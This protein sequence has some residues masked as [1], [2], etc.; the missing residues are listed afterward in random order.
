MAE[1]RDATFDEYGP[2]VES[3]TASSPERID[4]APVQQVGDYV[5]EAK[6]GEGGFG[7]VYRAVHRVIGKRVAIKV[8]SPKY[9]TDP[10]VLSRFISE[11]RAVN[12]I[13]HHHIVDIFS[14]GELPDGRRY[15]VM[16]YLEGQTLEA[17]LV[18][19]G[20]LPLSEVLA[21]LEP[22]ARALDAAHQAGIA[23]RDLK[24]A[25]IMLTKG[26]EG[27]PYPKLLDFGVAKLLDDSLPRAHR[28]ASGVAVGT[29]DYMSPEQVEGSGVDHRTDSYSF[30]VICYRMLTG[31]LPFKAASSVEMMIKHL[32]E[33]PRPLRALAP[34]V[35]EQIDR[36]VLKLLEKDRSR[37]PDSLSAWIQEAKSPPPPPRSSRRLALLVGVAIA[38]TAAGASVLLRQGAHP[39]PAPPPAAPPDPIAAPAVSPPPAPP[40]IEEQEAEQVEPPALEKKV[41]R[42]RPKRQKRTVTEDGLPTWED[43]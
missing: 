40:V 34:L 41:R 35:P 33:P 30:G 42:A 26:V 7:T 8:L 4:A 10:H 23:H 20:P 25:N 18:Q 31:E 17:H 24:P 21:I 39:M 11:A 28:T 19:R 37:R 5:V 29:P 43:P 9:S 1:S 15:F 3:G 13:R 2:T 16:E 6:L 32:R 14:F 12:Q 38:A 27:E 36:L 22:L